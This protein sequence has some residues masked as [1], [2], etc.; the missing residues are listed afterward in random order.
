LAVV[1]D[2]FFRVHKNSERL[3]AAKYLYT[4]KQNDSMVVNY[5][6]VAEFRVQIPGFG[7]NLRLLVLTFRVPLPRS[8]RYI[9]LFYYS[10]ISIH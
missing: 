3:G 7:T 9:V 10:F 6:N 2:G 1:N 8:F 5:I 4:A